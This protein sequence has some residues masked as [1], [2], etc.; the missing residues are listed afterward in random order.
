MFG[1]VAWVFF[2]RVLIGMATVVWPLI[3]STVR[4]VQQLL[5]GRGPH[6]R[7]CEPVRRGARSTLLE[8]ACL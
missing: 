3:V 1:A 7:L 2:G 6:E 5:P 4:A 8:L